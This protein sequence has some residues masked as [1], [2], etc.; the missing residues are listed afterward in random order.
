VYV[1]T[2]PK[3]VFER[4]AVVVD[5][6]TG[7][8]KVGFAGEDRPRSI[9]PTVY[10]IPKYTPVMPEY[11]VFEYYVGRDAIQ[12]RGALKLTWPVEHGIIQDW[13]GFEKIMH[14]IY[15]RELRVDPKERMLLMTEAPLAPRQNR[16]RMA[17]ILFEEF[18]VPA[19]YVATQAIL[20]LYATG[21]VTGLVIDSGDG[22]T[23]IVPIYESMLITHAIR[24]INIAGRDVTRYLAK[25]LTSRGYYF[26][27]SSELEIVRDIKEKLCYVALDYKKELEKAKKMPKA[28]AETYQLP[29]G[30]VLELVE[31]RFMAPEIMFNPLLIGKEEKPLDEAVYDAIF[32]CDIDIR[33]HMYENIV[34]SGG[35]TLI[36]NFAAR[37]KKELQELVPPAAREKINV[38]GIP[39]RLYA[40]WIGGSILADLPAF[41]KM[42]VTVDEWRKVGPESVLRTI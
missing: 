23:H 18:G 34:L 39:E 27:S 26:T 1:L 31:E 12:M 35:N 22:V 21:K 4:A 41:R 37:L 16:V 7:W 30:S 38:F 8:T 33:P 11:E 25:L 40:V 15:Y 28:I 2:V 14:Y 42:V 13:R 19:L 9:F 10:G 20:A 24:R 17:E 5:L 36:P 3:E 29:D 32:A 6:G